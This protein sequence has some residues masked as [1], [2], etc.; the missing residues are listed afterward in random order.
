MRRQRWVWKE[1]PRQAA[2]GIGLNGQV[3]PEDHSS[4][5]EDR[6]AHH[7]AAFRTFS[8][9]FKTKQKSW[10]RVD[11]ESRTEGCTGLPEWS[12]E[13]GGGDQG[14][15]LEQLTAGAPRPECEQREGVR[16]TYGRNTSWGRGGGAQHP[17]PAPFLLITWPGPMASLLHRNRK[18]G[19]IIAAVTSTPRWR[20]Q[21]FILKCNLFLANGSMD[22]WRDRKWVDM[23]TQH[24][25]MLMVRSKWWVWKYSLWDS[26]NFTV[27]LKW[28]IF[29]KR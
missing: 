15:P 23:I 20:P 9:G 13:P 19:V 10:V 1:D 17:S 21:Q 27:C 16:S 25:D 2:H 4:H 22:G 7:C 8:S 3:W 11:A 14:P 6:S 28:F 18:T 5:W 26:F 24:S 29:L 12:G